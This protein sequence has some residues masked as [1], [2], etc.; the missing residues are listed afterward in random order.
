MSRT[1]GG[2]IFTCKVCGRPHLIPYNC[3]PDKNLKII[4]VPCCFHPNEYR[5]YRGY[6]FERWVLLYPFFL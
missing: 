2:R 4:E 6:E 5:K 3:K 1:Y